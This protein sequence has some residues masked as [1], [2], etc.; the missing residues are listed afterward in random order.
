M[1][2]KM[3]IESI[4]S[5]RLLHPNVDAIKRRDNFLLDV[6][7]SAQDEDESKITEINDI[8][9]NLL[10]WVHDSKIIIKNLSIYSKCGGVYLE[11]GLRR[12]I[13]S[14][15]FAINKIFYLGS[16][17]CSQNWDNY[18]NDLYLKDMIEQL[19]LEEAINEDS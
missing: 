5:E 16:V 4:S 6:L 17:C 11:L 14:K 15:T 19:N 3:S 7:D 12:K 9:R 13:N 2:N 10:D 8:I 1:E 18:A